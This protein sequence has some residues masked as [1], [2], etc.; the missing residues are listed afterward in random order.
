M[1]ALRNTE[2]QP[3]PEGKRPLWRQGVD[4]K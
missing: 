4:W 2:L 1:Q 3:V